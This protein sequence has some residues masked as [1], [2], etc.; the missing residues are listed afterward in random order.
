MPNT[1]FLKA[2]RAVG[3][4]VLCALWCVKA[5]VPAGFMPSEDPKSAGVT[6]CPGHKKKVEV[7]TNKLPL[8]GGKHS[9]K[10]EDN[11]ASDDDSSGLCPF[12]ALA[13][14]SLSGEITMVYAVV[15]I[16][17]S[18][19]AEVS[20]PQVVPSRKQRRYVTSAPRSPPLV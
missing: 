12:T 14:P 17:I 19:P 11:S 4:A 3:L 15:P 1:P 20:L 5:A 18:V 16:L 6:V 10:D 7:S 2:L 13:A 9:R 8:P